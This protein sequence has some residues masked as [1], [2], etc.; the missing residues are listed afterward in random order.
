MKK[1]ILIEFYK[2]KSTRY[3]KVLLGLWLLAFCSI[4][5]FFYGMLSIIEKNHW[6]N[7]PKGALSPTNWPVFHFDS[8]WIN[9]G[10]FYKFITI[11]LCF[12]VV[13]SVA[14]EFR[15]D[16]IK[17][18]LI[19][20][21]SRKQFWLSKLSLPMVLAIFGTTLLFTLGTIL[22][23]NYSPDSSSFLSGIEHVGAYF[24]HITHMLTFAFFLTMLFK[25]SGVTLTLML[26]WI[27]IIEPVTITIMVNVAEVTNI[28]PFF[29]MEAGWRL[30]KF[31]LDQ[32]I[33]LTGTVQ[34]STIEYLT[35][36]GWIAV[37]MFLSYRIIQKRDC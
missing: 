2:I 10:Y 26:F 31:P 19:D 24:L 32:Y 1:L 33:H 23:L 5:I 37:F 17:Q 13:I 21:M 16:T 35:T 4:P 3:A 22:G 30:L 15:Y 29:P 12:L 14:R 20:G 7:V 9:I 34:N 8:V 18:N 27:Y 36:I 11:F 28:H 25:S 6:F